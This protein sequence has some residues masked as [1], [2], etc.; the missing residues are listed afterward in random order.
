MRLKALVVDD[1]SGVRAVVCR[2]LARVGLEC[3][4][5]EDGLEALD[6]LAAE[7]FQLVVT[8][9]RMPRMDGLALLS[10]IRECPEPHPKVVLITAQGSEQDAIA[11]V[12]GGAYDYI[13]KPFDPEDLIVVA[14]RATAPKSSD[15][16]ARSPLAARWSSPPPR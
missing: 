10:K 12:R 3:T 8:D 11:A 7:E 1:D 13:K 14:R 9:L 4:E 16:R 2:L 5:A 6:H 15:S